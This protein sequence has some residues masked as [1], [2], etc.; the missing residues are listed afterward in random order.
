MRGKS[1][2]RPP[3][4]AATLALVVA[5]GAQG[6]AYA[7]APPSQDGMQAAL[8]AYKNGNYGDALRGFQDAEEAGNA[9]AGPYI[10]DIIVNKGHGTVQDTALKAL[11]AL[12]KQRYDYG[13]YWLRMCGDLGNA[14]C[15]YNA[16]V[17]Y[18][19][20][21]GTPKNFSKALFWLRRAVAQG[22]DDAEVYLAGMYARGEGVQRDLAE[23]QRLLRTAAG[24]GNVVAQRR[25]AYAYEKGIGV[26]RDAAEAGRW[27]QQADATERAQSH[28][29]NADAARTAL[30][31]AEAGALAAGMGALFFY[32]L[33]NPP[34]PPPPD[35][36]SLIP[37]PYNLQNCPLGYHGQGQ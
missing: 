37:C 19:Q 20:G 12:Q 23:T 35:P 17:L 34:E 3:F 16:G 13:L 5:L 8:E 6:A 36:N 7:Q 22:S 9:D 1:K 33:S 14:G 2:L 18:A 4:R 27:K 32:G 21:G 11:H 26:P 10:Q 30:Q 28:K 29:A 25:I 31:T 24:R 15:Q